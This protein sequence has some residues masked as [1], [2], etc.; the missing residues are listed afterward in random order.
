MKF[1]GIFLNNPL[2][3]FIWE[4]RLRDLSFDE[5][6]DHEMVGVP[7]YY[8][9]EEKGYGILRLKKPIKKDGKFSY[10]LDVIDKFEEPKPVKHLG[11]TYVRDVKFLEAT[12]ATD[13]GGSPISG[14]GLQPITIYGKKKKE[15][16]DKEDVEEKL[17]SNE[18][19]SLIGELREYN[20]TKLTDKQLLNDW[21]SVNY[22][23]AQ[24]DN[25]EAVLP[26]NVVF[27]ISGDIFN[28]IQNRNLN[29][30]VKL[31]EVMTKKKVNLEEIDK[32]DKI[33]DCILSGDFISIVDSSKDNFT[34]NISIDKP[35]ESLSEVIERKVKNQLGLDKIKFSWGNGTYETYVPLY[36]L[37]LK[38]IYPNKLITVFNKDCK[39]EELSAP[40]IYYDID[41]LV[42]DLS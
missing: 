33:D 21:K 38:K 32:I 5:E 19:K 4:G 40:E 20:P 37:E 24:L 28:E 42:E 8:M 25:S 23:F 29:F 36:N 27:K 6:L 17:S 12:G 30:D 14:G 1:Q 13:V 15:K 22:W 2:A 39:V 34:I 35:N 10:A 16:E 41:K 31:Y 26:K 9:D 18:I 11:E 7:I 3:E